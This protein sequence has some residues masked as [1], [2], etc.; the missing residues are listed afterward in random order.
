ML[1]L[2]CKAK[3]PVVS[4]PQQVSLEPVDDLIIPEVSN[5]PN[6]GNAENSRWQQYAE[7]K[8]MIDV[9]AENHQY[10]GQQ[11]ITYT[12]N[13]PDQLNKLFYHLYFN[14]FQP[15][16]M[17]DVR[18]RTIP[19]PDPRVGDR[20]YNLS[21]EEIGYINVNSLTLNG[22]PLSYHTEGTILEVDLNSVIEPGETVTLEMSYDAQVPLQV[23][24][25]GRDSKEGI[26]FS[27]TQWYPKLCEYDYQGWHSNPYIGREF[28]GVWGN[29]DV[30]ILIDK[31]YK[32]GASG[33]LANAAEIGYGKSKLNKVK[34]DKRE[35]H[36]VAENVHD[37]A[38]AADPDYNHIIDESYPGVQ[39]HYLYQDGEL[40]TENWPE[41]PS[42][43]SEAFRYISKNY[44]SYPYPRYTF[45][46]GGDG[47]MEYPMATL[48]TGERNMNSLVGVSV[49]ELVHSWYQMILGTNEALYAW[50]DEGFTSYVSA[51]TMNHLRKKGLITGE[52]VE[53][54][55]RNTIAGFA[56]Y[57]TTGL[58][59]P[60]STHADHFH[61][62]RAYSVGSYTKGSVFLGQL[63]YIIGEES[64]AQ[65][66][67]DYF[68]TWKFKHPNVNDFIRVMEKTSGF[69]LDWYK[70]HMVNSTNV[71]EY[72]VDS[73]FQNG[74]E[75]VLNLGKNGTMPMPIDLMVIA[76]DGSQTNYTI[77][78][79][80]MRGEKTSEPSYGKFNVLT[81]W[82]WTHPGYQFSFEG[83]VNNIDQVI[84]DPFGRIADVDPINNIYPRPK[85]KN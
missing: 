54:P 58:E 29:F 71:I 28:H 66:M 21:E 38:W 73:L 70:E 76:K 3:N 74:N 43:M 82:P 44:G 50:M 33:Y 4:S 7:Y 59:E 45:I 61:S 36:F 41:L 26:D 11:V 27:M 34:T 30:K 83:D 24:R 31:S 79:R 75:V 8:M 35:W 53:D 81:D 63:K 72:S 16:S 6:V 46:Q 5:K 84:I 68:E 80:I 52:V 77:P 2:S 9:D 32:I 69:E 48:I 22:V 67:L 55:I 13:S 20:I 14:A 60:L 85:L 25:S 15:G 64:F 39:V 57:A 78:L 12:N 51:Q 10:S 65:G 19:D 23:R 42:I 56:R 47:G 1:L 37:F 49:H 17:M 62:N 40:A 18:S